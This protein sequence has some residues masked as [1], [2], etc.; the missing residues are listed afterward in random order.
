MSRKNLFNNCFFIPTLYFIPFRHNLVSCPVIRYNMQTYLNHDCQTCHLLRPS[1]ATIWI[2]SL[3]CKG[4]E[5]HCYIPER[6]TK[7][8]N[9]VPTQSYSPS[10]CFR[11][12]KKS[13]AGGGEGHS[14][15]VMRKNVLIWEMLSSSTPLLAP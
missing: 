10:F 13:G 12:L 3:T 9:N 4:K 8:W 11:L 14:D 2:Y 1:S 7:L 6:F 15:S 5:K